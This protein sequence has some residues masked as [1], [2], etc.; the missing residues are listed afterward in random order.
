MSRIKPGAVC[1]VIQSNTETTACNVGALVTAVCVDPL[2]QRGAKVEW[3]F[4][5]A[6]RP[7]KFVDGATGCNPVWVTRSH[8]DD[9]DPG[10]E[11]PNIYYAIP[12]MCLIPIEPPEGPVHDAEHSPLHEPVPA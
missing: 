2:Q 3:L 8:Y 9:A 5:D 11:G 6:S 12:A 1:V 7:L 4:Q 10:P